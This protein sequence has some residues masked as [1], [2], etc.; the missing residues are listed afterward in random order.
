MLVGS[1][2]VDDDECL[3]P[4]DRT[5]DNTGTAI[6]KLYGGVCMRLIMDVQDWVAAKG[7]DG[8]R[9]MVNGIPRIHEQSVSKAL[10]CVPNTLRSMKSV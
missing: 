9:W 3:C 4:S 1:Y 6:V 2:V 7:C 8:T 10:Q 5:C